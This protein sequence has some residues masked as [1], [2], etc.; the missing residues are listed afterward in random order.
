MCCAEE[1][2][3]ILEIWFALEC[4]QEMLAEIEDEAFS[5]AA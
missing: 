5:E 3:E 2:L 1:S 4:E